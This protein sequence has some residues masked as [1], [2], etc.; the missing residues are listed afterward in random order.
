LGAVVSASRLH[1]VGRG[2][3]SLSA[4]HFEL[5]APTSSRLQRNLKFQNPK[6]EAESAAKSQT[7]RLARFDELIRAWRL[8]LLCS[9]YV[10]VRSFLAKGFLKI[11]TTRFI[12]SMSHSQAAKASPR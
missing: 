2:F 7:P 11:G 8:G 10:G 1:R 12:S 4:H 5:Q 9:L 6:P 3:E